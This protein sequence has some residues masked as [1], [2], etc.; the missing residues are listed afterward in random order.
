M[1]IVGTLSLLATLSGPS[2]AF[3]QPS[4]YSS[5]LSTSST[6]LMSTMPPRSELKGYYTTLSQR[7]EQLEQNTDAKMVASEMGTVW[8][9]LGFADTQSGL[10]F[11]RESEIKHG[12]L[13]MLVSRKEARRSEASGSIFYGY[14]E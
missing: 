7:N 5:S 13:A 1:K 2:L 14:D 4:G 3:V 9:P 11:M 6:L 10:F 12:R 8:D